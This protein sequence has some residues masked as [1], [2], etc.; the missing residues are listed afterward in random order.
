MVTIKFM[1]FVMLS[2]YRDFQLC[3]CRSFYN[4]NCVFV[5]R[6][7]ISTTSISET[8]KSATVS[9]VHHI[10]FALCSSYWEQQTNA[11]YNMWNFQNWV[12]FSG[13]RVVEPFAKDSTLGLTDQIRTR[14]L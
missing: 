1:Y 4:S 10:R 7:T 8:Y 5:H 3:C 12:N 11:L 9:K 2:F 13:F 6:P 14:S